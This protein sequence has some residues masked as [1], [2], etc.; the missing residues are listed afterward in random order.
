LPSES[1]VRDWYIVRIVQI[2]LIEYTFSLIILLVF[3]TFIANLILSI[4][5]HISHCA[6]LVRC[7]IARED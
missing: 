1:S 7:K 2:H 5:V 3:G 4:N 6:R